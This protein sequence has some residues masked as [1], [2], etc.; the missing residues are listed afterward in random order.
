MK[1]A[2]VNLPA[3]LNW[4]LYLTMTK[5]RKMAQINSVEL[6]GQVTGGNGQLL[7]EASQLAS[8]NLFLVREIQSIQLNEIVQK[9]LKRTDVGKAILF[10]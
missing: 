3:V 8:E 4:V 10:E 7:A 5:F 9:G 1:N 2:G 6:I